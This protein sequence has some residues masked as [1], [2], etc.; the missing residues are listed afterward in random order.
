MK[1]HR[2][3]FTA[4]CCL[5]LTAQAFSAPKSMP[6][7]DGSGKAAGEVTKAPEARHNSKTIKGH[8]FVD[9]GLPSG[10]LWAETNIGA[11]TAYDDGY[12]FTWG[13]TATDA[14]CGSWDDYKFGLSSALTKYNST[15]KKT[16]LDTE[17]DAAYVNWGPRCHIPTRAEFQELIDNCTWSWISW[18]AYDGNTGE[19]TTTIG[20]KVTSKTNG[21]SIFLP[22]SGCRI[23]AQTMRNG[24][25]GYYWSSTH[26]TTNNTEYSSSL[27]GFSDGKYSMSGGSRIN[28]CTIRPVASPTKSREGSGQDLWV[29]D[30]SGNAS[31]IAASTVDFATFQADG[32]WFSITNGDITAVTDNIVY[33]SFTAELAADGAVKSLAAM[34]EIGICYSKQY[35]T[36]TIHDECWLV[37]QAFGRHS[38]SIPNLKAGTTYHCRVY[39]KLNDGDAVYGDVVEVT[40]TGTKVEDNSKTIDGHKFVDLGLPS[41]LLWAET[42][43]GADIAADDGDYLAWGETD[44]KED[45]V[46]SNY[47]HSSSGSKDVFTKYNETDGKA[48]LEPEDDAAYVNWGSYC[49]MHTYD[50]MTELLNL[51]YCTWTWTSRINSSGNTING[52]KITS[53]ANGNSIFLPASGNIYDGRL[54]NY[55][56]ECYYWSSTLR[57]TVDY[58]SGY[59]IW[60]RE[61]SN[62][63]ISTGRVR[64]LSVRP[65]AKP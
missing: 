41:G 61:S 27:L 11:E 4:L 25:N 48:V 59:A 36:P 29:L 58:T 30:G 62:N 43:I 8:K 55:G 14:V 32:N 65:V 45:Y 28:G 50:E 42:N 17:D 56:K 7:A 10:L 44:A 35:D 2:R 64:G 1:I 9:L 12:Y 21:S 49:R 15:D 54:R 3:I 13:E 60:L 46:W 39:I 20:Y 47:K 53:K 34:P 37:T 23:K 57:T 19:V 33:M 52:Y 18:S 26:A 5:F 40:T 38:A 6:E 24:T 63:K 16:E 51:N 22:A 31:S